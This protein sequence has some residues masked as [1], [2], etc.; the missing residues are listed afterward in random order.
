MNICLF[1]QTKFSPETREA[2]CHWSGP[3][4]LP[5]SWSAQGTLRVT[6]KAA[7]YTSDH[8]TATLKPMMIYELKSP[9]ITIVVSK[10]PSNSLVHH[11]IRLRGPIGDQRLH[12]MVEI[13]SHG[14]LPNVKLSWPQCLRESPYSWPWMHVHEDCEDPTCRVLLVSVAT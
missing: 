10:F 9:C 3:G 8:M 13:P 11:F 14:G 7:L 12:D 2:S 1:G 5:I 6:W 4:Q